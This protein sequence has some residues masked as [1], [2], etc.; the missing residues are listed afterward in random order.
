[1]HCKCVQ[2]RTR[3]VSECLYSLYGWFLVVSPHSI[4][5]HGNWTCCQPP[6]WLVGWFNVPFQHK[7]GYIR[8]D[9][10][11]YKLK[12]IQRAS[13]F[14]DT[15]DV[16]IS[17]R[18]WYCQLWSQASCCCFFSRKKIAAVE[19]HKPMCTIR[20]FIRIFFE[21]TQLFEVLCYTMFA[22]STT[23][24]YFMVYDYK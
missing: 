16:H 1:M 3:N 13:V 18:C 7:C 12:T 23:V 24:V 11:H 9:S 17:E 6:L 22:L 15:I 10:H 20:D 19:N 14:S 2:R 4:S 21:F 8:D 5:L